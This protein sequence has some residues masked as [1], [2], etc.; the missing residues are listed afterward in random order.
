MLGGMGAFR[1]EQSLEFVHPGLKVCHRRAEPL[2]GVIPEV[3]RKHFRHDDDG[4]SLEYC[5]FCGMYQGCQ[6]VYLCEREGTVDPLTSHPKSFGMQCDF[7]G[8]M[9]PTKGG[10]C[11]RVLHAMESL[12]RHSSAFDKSMCDIA[13]MVVCAVVAIIP[14]AI[15]MAWSPQQLC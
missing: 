6:M 1:H 12:V 2:G 9:G 8:E 14:V 3:V 13:V 10:V 11:H 4:R 15:A 7:F 5:I